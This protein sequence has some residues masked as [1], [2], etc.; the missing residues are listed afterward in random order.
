MEDSDVNV[1]IG[2]FEDS[3]SE[4]GSYSIKRN[5]DGEFYLSILRY[6][7]ESS[8]N[9]TSY[10]NLRDVFDEVLKDFTYGATDDYKKQNPDWDRYGRDDNYCGAYDYDD[11]E[12]YRWFIN[13]ANLK[14]H[15]KRIC[16]KLVN[17]E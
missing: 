16:I 5:D 7:S 4:D 12:Y 2:V 14:K 13:I 1:F 11:E 15:I 10:V 3:L 8:V 6:Y 17:V 9:D